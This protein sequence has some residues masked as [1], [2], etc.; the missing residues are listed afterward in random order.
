[1]SEYMT[2]SEARIYINTVFRIKRPLLFSGI[3][4]KFSF[5][6]VTFSDKIANEMLIL[7]A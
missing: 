1:M 2:E 3:T 4:L 6:L 5:K 7:T